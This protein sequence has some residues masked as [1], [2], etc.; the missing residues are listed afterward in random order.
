MK[1]DFLVMYAQIAYITKLRRQ[2]LLCV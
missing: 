1:L 2:Q